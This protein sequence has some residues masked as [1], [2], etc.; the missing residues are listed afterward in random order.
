VNDNGNGSYDVEVSWDPDA[1]LPPGVVITQPDRPPAS[2]PLQVPPGFERYVYAAKFV[3][4]VQEECDCRCLPV[5]PGVYATEIN[6][7]NHLDREVKIEKHVV[8][9]VFAGAAAGRE[10]RFGRRRASDKIV[11]PPHSATM[12]DC[13]RLA[14]L[15]LGAPSDSTLPITIGVLEIISRHPL[16]ITAVYTVTDAKSGSVSMDV[17]QI[18]GRRNR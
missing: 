14:E 11:L 10:P 17:E 2:F 1:T 4:G 13:C 12:D 3:C 15:L 7:H 9:V 5:R 6:I 18:L 8:P 16:S